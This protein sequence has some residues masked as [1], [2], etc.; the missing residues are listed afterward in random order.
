[1]KAK[2]LTNVALGIT[3]E[4]AYALCIV[5]CAFITCLII[6]FFRR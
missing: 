4:V 3:V 6:F 5:L 1:M 2:S